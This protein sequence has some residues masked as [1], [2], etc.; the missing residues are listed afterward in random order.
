MDQRDKTGTHPIK[1]IKAPRQIAVALQHDDEEAA[2]PKVVASGKGAIA[3]QI[4]QIAYA[5][6]V[7]VREDADLAQIL[8]LL[9]VESDIPLEA[10]AAVAEIL[11]YVYRAN[12]DDRVF[13]EEDFQSTEAEAEQDRLVEEEQTP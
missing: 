2:T 7:K 1:R 10:F 13:T 9:D 5:H 11:T 8:S 4:L 6:D 12:R 3:E